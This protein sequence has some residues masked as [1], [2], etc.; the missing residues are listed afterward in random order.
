MLTPPTGPPPK[1]WHMLGVRCVQMRKRDLTN[2]YPSACFGVYK[3]RIHRN[4]VITSTSY[5]DI[6]HD[7]ELEIS[8][9]VQGRFFLWG[10][11]DVT[12][13][14]D[15]PASVVG[16]FGNSRETDILRTLESP[17]KRV[18]SGST[19]GFYPHQLVHLVPCVMSIPDLIR[20]VP[21]R[22]RLIETPY[23][24]SDMMGLSLTI[25]HECQ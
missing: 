19:Y 16:S 22:S 17:E 8:V 9:V 5:E 3:K 15:G 11:S 14:N 12:A 1:D 20:T 18:A 4:L 21:D 13:S 25:V 6:D 10:S 2:T 23:W 24:A 7:S